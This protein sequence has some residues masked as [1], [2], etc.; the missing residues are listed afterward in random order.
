MRESGKLLRAARYIP[1]RP[2][3]FRRREKVVDTYTFAHRRRL[4]VRQH[5]NILQDRIA[6]ICFSGESPA[7]PKKSPALGES[8]RFQAI[9]STHAQK[10]VREPAF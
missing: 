8:R 9:A 6:R 3:C 5:R 2:K 7:K 10:S 1:H 4:R